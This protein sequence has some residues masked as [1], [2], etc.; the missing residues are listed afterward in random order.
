MLPGSPGKHTSCFDLVDAQ[1]Q[2]GR[3][4]CRLVYKATERYR[5]YLLHEAVLAPDV[6]A[7]LKESRGFCPQHAQMLRHKPG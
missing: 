5:D 3:P 7:K 4:I 1:S 2:A 6:R